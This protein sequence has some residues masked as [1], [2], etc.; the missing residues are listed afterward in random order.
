MIPRIVERAGPED[1][2]VV[3]SEGNDW[4]VT[5]Y[6]LVRPP[7]RF[8]SDHESQIPLVDSKVDMKRV[9]QRPDAITLLESLPAHDNW[10]ALSR[11]SIQQLFAWFLV[12]EDQQRRLDARPIAILAHQASLVHHVLSEPS[13]QNALIADEVGLGKTIEAALIIKDL[14]EKQPGLRILYLAPA[15]LVRNVQREFER[16]DLRFRLWIAGADR[17][18]RLDDRLVVASIHRAAHESHFE[19]VIESGPWN[20]VIVDECHHLTDWAAGGGKPTRKYRLVD[21]LREK[22]PSSSRLILMSGTPHQGH[23][24]RFENLL[25]LLCRRG[26]GLEHVRGRVIYRTKEDV[27]DWDGNPLFPKR[28]VNPPIPVDLGPEHRV[29]LEHIHDFFTA[30]EPDEYGG[31]ARRR[32]AGWRA[33]QALQWAC[34]SVQAGLGYMVRQAIRLGWES[35][36]PAL[37]EALL[38]IRPYRNGPVDEAPDV[39]LGR[40]QR[41]IGQQQDRGDL[42]DIEEEDDQRWRPDPGSL[43]NLL[44]EGVELLAKDPDTKWRILEEEVLSKAGDEKIV[45]FAQP[46]ETVTA[47]AAYLERTSGHR[48]AL[49]I[50][51]QSELERQ[52]EIDAFWRDDGPRY[53]VSSR[54]GG[55]GLNLQIARRL[56]HVD[57]PWN[58]MEME[59]RVGRVH[60]FMSK[61][62]IIVDTLVVKDSREAEAYAVAFAKLG[63]IAGAMVDAG[64]VEELFARV[65]SIIPPDAFLDVL[66]ERATGPLNEEERQRVTDLVTAGFE[67]WQSFHAEY[68]DQQKQ[69]RELD[70]GAASLDDLRRFAELHLGAT[71]TDGF[72]SLKFRWADGEVVESPETAAVFSVGDTPYACGDYAGMPVTSAAGAKAEPFGLNLPIA[73]KELRRLAFPSLPSGGAHVRWPESHPELTGIARPFGILGVVRLTV[74]NSDGR[75]IERGNELRIYIQEQGTAQPRELLGPEKGALVRALLDAT[76]RREPPEPSAIPS[77]LR[78]V[79]EEIYPELCRPTE[80]D[81][82]TGIRHALVPLFAATIT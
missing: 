3:L 22:L 72:S 59:Q 41:E 44:H 70:P 69:I 61:K 60:R 81:Q 53:L 65:M 19:L 73:A 4:G 36:N 8:W 74:Q 31:Q 71:S 58:P 12:C 15:R 7:A 45:L 2:R 11:R 10:Q 1:L 21:E 34:S 75:W 79:L 42:D 43:T 54:A 29:W 13:L 14:L 50:G 16:L 63:T 51:N 78:G 23:A 46:I 40:I 77:R 33:G 48:P 38:A 52:K 28:Q 47:L 20:V 39:L 5:I 56:V 82:E 9:K 55:E 18:A 68:A 80:L 17:D 37:R 30:P 24:S 25:K 49:I 27:R 64:R 62:T 32:A 76:V 57:V 26:E 66:A 6:E 35:E 67:Q